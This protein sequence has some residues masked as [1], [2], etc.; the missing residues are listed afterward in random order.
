[1]KRVWIFILALCLVITKATPAAAQIGSGVLITEVM[2]A[3][4]SSASSEFVEIYNQSDAAVDVTGWKIQ[5]SS[6]TGSTIT[7]KSTLS[8]AIS[9]HGFV[10]VGSAV[11]QSEQNVT[12]DFDLSSGLSGTAGR[13]RIVDSS[14]AIIDSLSY[15][16]SAL[17]SEGTPASSP[18]ASQSLKRTIDQ[19]A[20]FIDN[21]ENSTDFV[22]S[23]EPYAQGGGVEE[24]APTPVDVCPN[25]NDNQQSLPVD[26]EFDPEGNCV[27]KQVVTPS[28]KTLTITELLPNA[29]GS[30]TGAEYIEIYN[31]NSES[32][33]LDGYELY[34]GPNYEKQ[35]SFPDNL[36]IEPNQY[37]SFYNSDINFTLVNTNSRA[38]LVAP[39]GNVV[40]KTESY[41]SPKEGM[42]WSLFEGGWK[43]SQKTTPDA[44]N[45]YVMIEPDDDAV[46]ESTQPSCRPDQFRNPA[47]N[48][49]KKISSSTSSLQAC[50]ADQVR[51]PL[52]NR[53][54]KLSSTTS[55]L[56]ACK[57]GQER[58]PETNRCRKISSGTK[59]LTPCQPGYERNQD[60]NR[61][62]KATN[63]TSG[64]LTDAAAINPINLNSRIIALLLFM[65]TA[66]GVY[67]YRTDI[68]NFINRLRNKRGD[69]RPPG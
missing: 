33:G 1:M 29:V 41:D 64:T 16:D 55:V 32:I 5:Y 46:S 51:N 30:D 7:T 26:Y 13:I 23:D 69:P 66:Y 45:E 44:P 57:L 65:A 35:Y 15:G 18:Q 12:A 22:I 59:K 10:L 4:T 34:I 63:K 61:C 42:S 9:S 28:D 67:E 54:R 58:N 27:P 52:T 37:L 24:L 2:T 19:D 60:T 50:A 40:S 38:E 49:C 8:G 11:F 21:N 3:S 14:E 17:E 31:P 6:A 39:A 20:R 68:G 62:K 47:T 43:F 53:C 25:I 48:R 36:E 56:T